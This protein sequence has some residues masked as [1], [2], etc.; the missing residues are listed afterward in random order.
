MRWYEAVEKALVIWLHYLG[1]RVHSG[2]RCGRS[3]RYHE[4][5]LE[6]LGHPENPF[7]EIFTGRGLLPY[8]RE[9]KRLRS[10][11]RHDKLL[12]ATPSVNWEL[13]T[14]HLR[15]VNDALEDALETFSD[16]RVGIW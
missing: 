4:E 2:T 16:E 7:F 10:K 12:A 14:C 6:S 5:V 15:I 1:V 3:H 9:D 13:L 8:L 11:W